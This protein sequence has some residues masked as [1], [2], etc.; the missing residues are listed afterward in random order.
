[1]RQILN[2]E[3]SLRRYKNI[4]KYTS[5]KEAIEKIIR[6]YHDN[7]I[8]SYT[9]IAVLVKQAKEITEE[10]SKNQPDWFVGRRTGVLRNP[11]LA[12]L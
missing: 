6:R 5:L 2:N 10:D 12:P 11:C 1:M 9:T 4:V 3:I 7:A 8:D